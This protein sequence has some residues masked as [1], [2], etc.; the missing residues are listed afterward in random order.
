VRIAFSGAHRVGKSTLIEA[1][2][3]ALGGYT[4]VDEP[5][6]LL[7][8]D[9]YE[10]AHPPSREDFEAQLE[11]SLAALEE[12]EQDVL[13]DRCPLDLVAYLTIDDDEF[14]PEP[15]L[16]R[17]RTAMG[18][19]DL[20]VYVPIEGRVAVPSEED[21]DYRRAVDDKL[22]GLLV[23]DVLGLEMDILTVGGDLQSRIAQVVARMK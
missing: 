20:V 22:R 2:A 19:L 10:F 15:L 13:F 1:I 18:T 17:I 4:T 21:A 8:E 23:D 5:Y 12:G 16:P 11:R 7:E 9:G 14:D 3:D 6:H